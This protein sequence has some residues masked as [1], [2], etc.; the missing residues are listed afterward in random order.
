MTKELKGWLIFLTKVEDFFFLVNLKIRN[1]YVS[2]I[3]PHRLVS[4]Q[5]KTVYLMVNMTMTFFDINVIFNTVRV[6]VNSEGVKDLEMKNN[7]LKPCI[8]LPGYDFCLNLLDDLKMLH[9]PLIPGTGDNCFFYRKVLDGYD[10]INYTRTDTVTASH[11]RAIHYIFCMS[12]PWFV[13]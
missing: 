1:L 5:K 10:E 11:Q 9:W 7:F 13:V 6:I 12:G 3:N 4:F 8:F 2:K